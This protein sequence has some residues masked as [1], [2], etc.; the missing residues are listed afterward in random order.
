MAVKRFYIYMNRVSAQAQFLGN[1]FFTVA[2][3]QVLQRLV[4]PPR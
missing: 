2:L 4:L 1:L 3:K